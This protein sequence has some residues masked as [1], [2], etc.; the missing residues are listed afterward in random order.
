[1]RFVYEHVRRLAACAPLALT[2]CAAQAHDAPQVL[3]RGGDDVDARVGIVD[4]A[5]GYLVDRQAVALRPVEELRVEEPL[6]VLDLL[7][8][9]LDDLAP[10]GLEA[11]LGIGEARSE[12]RV[13]QRVVAT[14]D[15]SVLALSAIVIANGIAS[16]RSTCSRSLRTLVASTCCSL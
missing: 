2:G 5:D 11:A 13:Q 14:R 8:E 6:V 9:R 7:Q 12:Q 4:P 3:A 16:S 1:M 10:A 15:Q